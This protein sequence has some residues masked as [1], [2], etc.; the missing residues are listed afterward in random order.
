VLTAIFIYS[1]LHIHQYKTK[2]RNFKRDLKI[3]T[4]SNIHGIWAMY[5]FRIPFQYILLHAGVSA[6]ISAVIAQAASGLIAT[7]VRMYLNYKN[8]IFAH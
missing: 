1:I 3:I 5:A 6:A 2:E 8:K 4:F 7:G